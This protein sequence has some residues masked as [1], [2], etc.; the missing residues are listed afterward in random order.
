VD[1]IHRSFITE[2]ESLGVSNAAGKLAECIIATARHFNLG[3]DWMDS[4]ADT[5]LPMA[6]A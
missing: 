1:Y 2:M 5:V 4:Q 3:A 6:I